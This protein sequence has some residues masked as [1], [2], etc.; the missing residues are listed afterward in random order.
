MSLPSAVMRVRSQS[1]QKGAVTEAMIPT[2]PAGWA[3][4]SRSVPAATSHTA[5]GRRSGRPRAR[6]VKPAALRVSST[7]SAPTTSSARQDSRGPSGMCSM[8]RRLHPRRRHSPSSRGA[9]S[10]SA[11]GRATALILIGDR[12]AARAPANP[13]RTSARRSRRVTRAYSAGSRESIETLTRSSPAFRRPVARLSS[14]SPLVVRPMSGLFPS[15]RVR[16]SASA[17]TISSRSLRMSGSPPVRRMRSIPRR[18]TASRA[19][20]A[21]SAASSRLGPGSHARPAAGMQ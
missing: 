1:A 12:P 11:S 14:P 5:A 18:S 17:A 7:W 19:S 10:A 16:S 9:R 13:R 8:K 15:R 2:V 4:P 21:I 3:R 6:S 20:R